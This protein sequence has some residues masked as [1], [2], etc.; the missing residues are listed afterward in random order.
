MVYFRPSAVPV[1]GAGAVARGSVVSD[2]EIIGAVGREGCE[3][4]AA[5]CTG[6]ADDVLFAI[7]FGAGF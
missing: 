1:A 3:P 4:P 5:G 2:A 7:V 6:G